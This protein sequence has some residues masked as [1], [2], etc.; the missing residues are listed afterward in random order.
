MIETIGEA[1]QMEG[2]PGECGVSEPRKHNRKFSEKERDL[3]GGYH[4]ESR[5]Q[6]KSKK[7]PLA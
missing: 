1:R 4:Q 7:Y 6:I 5:E 2:K 3:C